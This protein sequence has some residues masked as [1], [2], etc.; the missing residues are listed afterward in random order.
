MDIF[1]DNELVDITI[2]T[3]DGASS[4]RLES[5]KA[6][7]YAHLHLH[8]EDLKFAMT[9]LGKF[10]EI[11]DAFVKAA[12]WRCAVLH[13]AKCYGVDSRGQLDKNDVLKDLPTN[14]KE[15]HEQII[16]LRNKHIVHDENPFTYCLTGAMINPAD[17]ERKVNTIFTL[18]HSLPDEEL[19]DQGVPK[20]AHLVSAVAKFLEQKLE[21]LKLSIESDLE[22]KSHE[23]LM[24]YKPLTVMRQSLDHI[25]SNKYEHIGK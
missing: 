7:K 17:G 20:L 21:I 24:G 10:R 4:V 18:L 12:L 2:N 5:R 6:R 23:E 22:K 3:D 25:G 13:Y 11:D 9:C 8:L 14:A 16:H 19:T 15:F 1:G